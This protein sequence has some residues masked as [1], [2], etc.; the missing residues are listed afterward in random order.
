MDIKRNRQPIRIGEPPEPGF[1]IR[2]LV[3]GGPY[4]GCQIMYDPTEG[5]RIMED[6]V[7]E[8]PMKDPWQSEMG[9]RVILSTKTTEAE[10]RFRIGL[11]RY[12]EV[13][14]PD[15]VAANPRKPID[16]NKSVPF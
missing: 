15:G 8:G 13:Y 2:R 11:K 16:P 4:V 3:R 1:Y 9:E 14:Q 6:G 7:W 5:Y 12:Q 10:V